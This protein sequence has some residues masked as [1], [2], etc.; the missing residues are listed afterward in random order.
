LLKKKVIKI[1]WLTYV[2]SLYEGGLT[3]DAG[4]QAY[5]L[6]SVKV[7]F[8]KPAS[9]NYYSPISNSEKEMIVKEQ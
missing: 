3:K 5:T 2:E 1:N 6:K 8:K 9:I 4:H 7:T